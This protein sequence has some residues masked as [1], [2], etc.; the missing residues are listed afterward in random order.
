V[1]RLMLLVDRLRSHNGSAERHMEE[2]L[3]IVDKRLDR[4]MSAQAA[5]EAQ[6][7]LHRHS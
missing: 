4:V 5:R 2:R 3:D 1:D 7:A 6:R